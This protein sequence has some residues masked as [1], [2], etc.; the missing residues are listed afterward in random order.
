MNQWL[1]NWSE[2]LEL[3]TLFLR[4]IVG[5]KQNRIAPLNG[6]PLLNNREYNAITSVRVGESALLV[7]SLSRQES[8]A[9]TGIPGLSEIPGF[10]NTTNN[11]SDLDVAELAIVITPH[12]VRAVHQGAQE[13]M[14]MLPTAP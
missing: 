2:I 8:N 4:L 3:N 12:I 1:R 11:D 5:S 10:Q 7:S 6:L 14:I 13:K 9:I